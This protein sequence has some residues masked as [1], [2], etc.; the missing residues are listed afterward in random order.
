MGECRRWGRVNDGGYG[1][2]YL[3]K[4]ARKVVVV[5]VAAELKLELEISGIG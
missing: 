4:L 5:D 2:G 3:A 1:E